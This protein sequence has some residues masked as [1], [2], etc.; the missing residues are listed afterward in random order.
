MLVLWAVSSVSPL[1]LPLRGGNELNNKTNLRWWQILIGCL[2]IAGIV[3]G[4]W[5]LIQKIWNIFSGLQKEIAVA[6]VAGTV[7]ILV[8]VFSIVL[9][10]YYER[11]RTIELE[12]REKKIPVYEK[13]VSFFVD[14][15]LDEKLGNRQ[16]SEKEIMIF[17]GEFT[18]KIMVWGSDEV[19]RKWSNYRLYSVE[20]INDKE[21]SSE[22]MFLI[23]EL[24]LA[25]RKDMGH[26][27]TNVQ[28]GEILG[29]FINDIKD[30]VERR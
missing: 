13:F 25:I 10:K 19:L 9:G 2:V 18:Q 27:N 17:F 8:S 24:L 26:K 1:G 16:M 7:T 20:H 28:R 5:F 12:L 30:Y 6:I 14:L 22:A 23:E 11:K 3:A 15:M 21:Y 4:L 29:L